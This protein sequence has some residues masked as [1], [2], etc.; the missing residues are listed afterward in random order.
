M[1]FTVSRLIC[2]PT[3]PVG[4]VTEQATVAFILSD[5]IPHD[6][7]STH[8]KIVEACMICTGSQPLV[9]ALRDTTLLPQ[10]SLGKISRAKMQSLFERGYFDHEIETYTSVVRRLMANGHDAPPD[11]TVIPTREEACLLDD[12]RE[13]MRMQT[14][15]NSVEFSLNTPLFE[16]SFTSIDLVRL[17]RRI[18]HRLGI[19]VPVIVLMKNP[20]IRRLAVALNDLVSSSSR[21][22]I[23]SNGALTASAGDYDPVVV[24]RD[25]GG[26]TPL[27]LIH[28][29]VG[30]VLVFVG[31]AQQLA[32][33][34][35]LVFALRARGFEPGQSHFGSIAEMVDVYAIAVRS[36][37]PKGPYALGGYSYGAI[38]A[39]ELAKALQAQG[40][41]VQ[42]LAVCNLPPHIAWRMRQL[43]W[44]PCLLHLCMF[45]GLVNEDW[46]ESWLNDMNDI[47]SREEA[48]SLVQKARSKQRWEELGLD[49][50]GLETWVNLA[51]GLQSMAV[52][53]EPSGVVK[54][55][56]VFHAVPLKAAAKSRKEWL[57][58]HLQTWE[59][60][61]LTAPRFHEVDGEHYTMLGPN[62]VVGFARILRQ[63]LKERGL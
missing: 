38:V 59:D 33:D 32:T 9:F 41:T 26:R 35:R 62:H 1:D 52:D 12:F 36:H 10:S 28:P 27:W 58:G 2:F 18:D 63:A 24:L 54:T 5:W 43:S 14:S 45:L 21:Q 53:Y 57:E 46:V 60:F 49:E 56:D 13:I 8:E 20:T 61:C 4:G 31:L 29:G 55:M 34:E 17:K 19:S 25:S 11:E 6:I 16:L 40:E 50:N 51:Y 23:I 3:R 7:I 47:K 15:K 37:Q 44:I 42:F 22:V 48:I 30:E 39:F